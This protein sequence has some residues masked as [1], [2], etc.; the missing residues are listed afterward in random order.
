[1]TLCY[2]VCAM[3]ILQYIPRGQ[4]RDELHVQ[5]GTKAAVLDILYATRTNTCHT[6]RDISD[7]QTLTRVNS[8][9]DTRDSS[10]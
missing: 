5:N 10:Q 3:Y 9:P 8:I 7:A 1:M 6:I 2:V 4:G